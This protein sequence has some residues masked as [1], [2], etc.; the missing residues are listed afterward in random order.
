MLFLFLCSS[1]T[2]SNNDGGL[3]HNGREFVTF[4]EGFTQMTESHQ[5]PNACHKGFRVWFHWEQDIMLNNYKCYIVTV[6]SSG[7]RKGSTGTIRD[8]LYIFLESKIELK[9]NFALEIEFW[10]TKHFTEIHIG[11]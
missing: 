8:T 7:T 11:V 10:D 9:V 1:G 2:P 5:S 4:E 3:C 6:E